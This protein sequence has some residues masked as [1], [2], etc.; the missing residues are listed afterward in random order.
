MP[1]GTCN[2]VSHLKL[3]YHITEASTVLEHQVRQGSFCPHC[4]TG[5]AWRLLLASQDLRSQH[6]SAR[7]R[8]LPPSN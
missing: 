8:L 2:C 5:A 3:N 4:V 6:M 1:L 7:I